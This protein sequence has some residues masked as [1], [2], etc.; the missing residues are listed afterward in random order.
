MLVLRE[1][2]FAARKIARTNDARIAVEQAAR[3]QRA[4]A[5]PVTRRVD[6]A[7]P[8]YSTNRAS[9]GGGGSGGGAVDPF[10]LLLFALLAGWALLG[11]FSR[12]A[13]PANAATRWTKAR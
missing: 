9:H 1:E 13:Q 11:R 7:Q 6:N 3:Q 4:A 10:A 12:A 5:A 2:Q 8:M